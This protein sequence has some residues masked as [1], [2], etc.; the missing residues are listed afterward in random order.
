MKYGIEKKTLPDPPL[1]NYTTQTKF[2]WN[3][4]VCTQE[5]VMTLTQGQV[6]GQSHSADIAIIY[7]LGI[8][9]YCL[10]ESG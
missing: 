8:T 5:C 9:P 1:S 3:N 6:Q 2:Y 4:S 10:V 7:F